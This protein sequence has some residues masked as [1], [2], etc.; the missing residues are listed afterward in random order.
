VFKLAT[1]DRTKKL[2]G[3][4]YGLWEVTGTLVENRP[5]ILG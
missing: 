4:K 1:T 5:L 2:L 3:K